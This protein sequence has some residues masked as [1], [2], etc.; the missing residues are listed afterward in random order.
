MSRRHSPRRRGRSQVGKPRNWLAISLLAGAS[1]L[2]MSVAGI[3]GYILSTKEQPDEIGCLPSVTNHTMMFVDVSP[4]EWG[5]GQRRDI[6]S[7]F[8]NVFD[9]LRP[10][11]KLTVLTTEGDKY[12]SLG[13]TPRTA[14]CKP[15][16]ES[17]NDG[18]NRRI[19]AKA[20]DEHVAPVV[21]DL[22]DIDQSNGDDP[23]SQRSQSPL[24][25]TF[26]AI[27]MRD[28]FSDEAHSRTLVVISDMIHFSEHSSPCFVK[29]DLPPYEKIK[30]RPDWNRIAPRSFWG[31]DVEVYFLV[32]FGYGVIMPYCNEKELH[33]FWTAY[34]EDAGAASVVIHR[35]RPDV[36]SG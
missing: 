31:A 13:G 6:K 27:S 14:L 28:D 7:I 34:F 30:E 15:A 4:P 1:L 12:T 16:T 26:R 33:D 11:E 23:R 18:F 35:L 25:E 36:G 19:Y 32:R 10:A 24:Y 22:M 17:D 5:E 20:Y 29:G 9:R 2:V 21:A 8:S 3:G